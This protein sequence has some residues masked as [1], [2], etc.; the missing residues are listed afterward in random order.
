MFAL[1]EHS[2]DQ[3]HSSRVSTPLTSWHCKFRPNTEGLAAAVEWI[4][5][6]SVC[7]RADAKAWQPN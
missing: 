5:A 4:G 2:C 6:T 7:G 1:S 3:W